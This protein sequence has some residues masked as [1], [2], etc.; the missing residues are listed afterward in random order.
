MKSIP[1]SVFL[2]FAFVL[3]V[4]VLVAGH[5][6]EEGDPLFDRMDVNGDGHVSRSESVAG[7][8]KLFAEI[9]ANHDGFVTAAEMDAYQAQRKDAAIRFSS[10]SQADEGASRDPGSG[11][12]RADGSVSPN[13]VANA[14][15]SASA[16]RDSAGKIRLSDRDGDGRLSA[17]EFEAR[18]AER[19]RRLDT[20]RDGTLSRSECAAGS[21]RMEGN[22]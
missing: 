17:A 8:K 16:E 11:A 18:A 1:L 20:D 3:A 22:L 12:A 14:R 5:D 10:T 13:E 2:A 7:A 19:F 4:P 21:T 9:D 15:G 6:E